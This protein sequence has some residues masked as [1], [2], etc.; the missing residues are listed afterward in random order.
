M[1]NKDYK[2]YGGWKDM[3]R[4]CTKP[5]R[6]E[7]KNY[8]GRGITVCDRWNDFH[9]F[10]ADMGEKP[11]GLS[12]D[13]IDNNKGYSPDNCRWATRTQQ[14]RNTRLLEAN[15]TGIAGVNKRGDNG[16]WRV[17]MW[18]GNGKRI[19]LGTFDDFFEACCARKSG[20]N[21]YWRIV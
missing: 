13:R 10:L 15:T 1:I 17:R 18:V 2:S 7:F 11:E 14:M 3:R 5:S 20:E 16:N 21:S 9:N 6:K 12:I 4:R 19:N 8:G